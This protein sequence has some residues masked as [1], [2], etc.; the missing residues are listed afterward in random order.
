MADQSSDMREMES[1]KK[2][3]K[4]IWTF[5]KAPL[6]LNCFPR[7]WNRTNSTTLSIRRLPLLVAFL[8]ASRLM[9]NKL[10]FVHLLTAIPYKKAPIAK[11]ITH[12]PIMAMYEATMSWNVSAIENPMGV[13]ASNGN[14]WTAKTVS[15]HPNQQ[16]K[17]KWRLWS[18]TTLELA[19]QKHL[20]LNRLWKNW[21]SHKCTKAAQHR[22]AILLQ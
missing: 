1:Q 18:P 9:A 7:E 17:W 3:P 5:L 6:L 11:A 4:Y 22:W 16:I 8:R 12:P 13:F 19:A 10:F 20:A 2:T 14:L 21:K 15:S